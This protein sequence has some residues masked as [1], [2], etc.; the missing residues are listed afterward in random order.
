MYANHGVGSVGSS[1][2]MQVTDD[3]E[4][5]LRMP[6]VAGS[7]DSPA[8][9]PMA[10]VQGRGLDRPTGQY[11][12]I[13]SGIT[14]EPIRYF[15]PDPLQELLMR[16]P[17]VS[18]Q[19]SPDD[20][21]EIQAAAFL[22]LV[23]RRGYAGISDPGQASLLF[24]LLW[25]A[26]SI[27]TMADVHA[28]AT[29]I[30]HRAQDIRRQI[31]FTGSRVASEAVHV[32]APHE[33]VPE[34]MEQLLEGIRFEAREISAVDWVSVFGFF[35][36]HAH[37]FRD[38]NGRWTRALTLAVERRSLVTTMAA[39]SFQ[40]MCMQQLAEDIWP[41]TRTQGLSDYLAAS[42][43]Y[44][45]RLLMAYRNSTAFA[46]IQGMSDAL[47][48]RA[49]A[50]PKLR[51]LARRLFVEGRLEVGKTRQLLGASVRVVDGLFQALEDCGL[52]A[53]QQGISIDPLL[54]KIAGQAAAS[55]TL[56]MAKM[57]E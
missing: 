16:C 52:K 18:L 40:T 55:A 10:P 24:D 27:E 56:S 57:K 49:Y 43:A 23:A 33:A 51:A 42:R 2:A 39:M 46:S 48:R 8:S 17:P 50:K 54:D 53:F 29:L 15:I 11:I 35:C 7:V 26:P 41:L 9:L 13:P 20:N 21:D 6:K 31:V 1:K 5:P 44:T 14:H 4:M 22:R 19:G 37:P 25:Q 45:D 36:V 3:R 32:Y 38:G 47:R 30:D 12:H 34:L 28:L